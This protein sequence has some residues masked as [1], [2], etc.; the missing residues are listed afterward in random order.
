MRGGL[1]AGEGLMDGGMAYTLNAVATAMGALG[2]EE[3]PC[4]PKHAL[5]LR[6][7]PDIH[8]DPFDCMLCWRIIL[9]PFAWPKSA[10]NA[11]PIN[12]HATLVSTCCR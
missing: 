8:K 10:K 1:A 11:H 7:L 12:T 4:A 6:A 2:R 3:V 9:A 5:A